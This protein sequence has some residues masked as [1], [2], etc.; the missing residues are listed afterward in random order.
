M[1]G[2]EISKGKIV[3]IVMYRYTVLKQKIRDKRSSWHSVT[4]ARPPQ[5]RKTAPHILTP[6]SLNHEGQRVHVLK[7][8]T[9]S[10]SEIWVGPHGAALG[11]GALS[12]GRALAPVQ[13]H[14]DQ[15]LPRPAVSV[16]IGGA[17]HGWWH[18]YTVTLKGICE[19]VSGL[20]LQR[21]SFSAYGLEGRVSTATN[22]RETT[23]RKEGGD[24]EL[25]GFP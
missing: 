8:E 18:Q 17:Q 22:Y 3:N 6:E 16:D 4:D 15:A 13:G 21:P 7:S 9:G 5:F 20:S 12:C 14:K 1:R 23:R 11:I 25:P 10:V 24:A 2:T 19:K